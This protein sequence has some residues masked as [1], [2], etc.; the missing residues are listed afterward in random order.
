M[1]NL[2]NKILEEEQKLK[3]L[4]EQACWALRRNLGMKLNVLDVK[5]SSADSKEPI[6]TYVFSI[7]IFGK[8]QQ[9][10]LEPET[11]CT[12]FNED[13]TVN[14]APAFEEDR[15][16][17]LKLEQQ[18]ASLSIENQ[19][20]LRLAHWLYWLAKTTPIYRRK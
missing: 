2:N 17:W 15:F 11:R 20:I 1:D 13:G 14:I 10:W 5:Y 19:N 4:L 3:Y 18:M 7:T 6:R 16:G 9:C 12:E 8:E